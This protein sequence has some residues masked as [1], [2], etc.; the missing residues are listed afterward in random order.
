[1]QI[2][3][4][5]FHRKSIR[6][7][8]WFEAIFS[9]CIQDPP[10]FIHVT[11]LGITRQN[12]IE[13]FQTPYITRLCG[14][15]KTECSVNVPP[16]RPVQQFGKGSVEQFK[17]S[18]FCPEIPEIPFPTDTTYRIAREKLR[19]KALE[20]SKPSSFIVAKAAKA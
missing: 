12:N 5:H 10:S 18:I 3:P 2:F 4:Q 16:F 19:I 17:N 11:P 14:C 9:H 15:Q 20:T 8:V 6:V 1:M 7:P 13:V